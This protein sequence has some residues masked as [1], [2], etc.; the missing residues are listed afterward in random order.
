MLSPLT[1]LSA[2]GGEVTFFYMLYM[3][4][5]GSIAWESDAPR[6]C[7]MLV[8]SDTLARGCLLCRALVSGT[9]SW[10]LDPIWDL[11]L[12]L[13]GRRTG[14]RPADRAF[15]MVCGS[16][17][18][19]ASTCLNLVAQVYVPPYHVVKLPTY[20]VWLGARASR[21]GRRLGWELTLPLVLPWV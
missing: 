20:V 15:W 21:G 7:S 16:N 6:V 2:L 13:W 10:G 18:I 11:S 14:Q 4:N 5:L 12:A 9:Q 8:A 1:F 19:P 17:G 3:G